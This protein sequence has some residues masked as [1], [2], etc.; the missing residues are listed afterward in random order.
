MTEKELFNE[1]S[2]KLDLICETYAR[3]GNQ[4]GVC[5]ELKRIDVPAISKALNLNNIHYGADRMEYNPNGR[6]NK[7]YQTSED[8]A[9]LDKYDI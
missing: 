7:A 1:R 9:F 4:R 2:R 8:L 5:E 6:I 3:I